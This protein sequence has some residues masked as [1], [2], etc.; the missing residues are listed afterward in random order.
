MIVPLLWLAAAISFVGEAPCQPV[1]GEHIL[2]RDL[3]LAEARFAGLGA[4]Q[5][6]G[7]APE[8]GAKRVFWPAELLRIAERNELSVDQPL[9]QV[10]FERRTR[11]LTEGEIVSAVR[12]WAPDGSQ[13][14]LLDQSEPAVPIG[15]LVLPKPG[16][17]HSAPDGSVLLRGY[18]LFGAERRFPMWARLRFNI[19]KNVVVASEEIAAGSEISDDQV[20]M[21][22]RS[23]GIEATEVATDPPQVVGR[24]ATKHL[25]AGE[26]IRLSFLLK[27]K[28]VNAGS[29]V[30]VEVRDGATRLILEGRAETSGRTGELVMVRNP[31]SGKAFQARVT[32]EDAVLVIP[33]GMRFEGKK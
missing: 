15:T 2:G 27:P 7:F 26:S 5:E 20:R 14:T 3:A 17:F 19:E 9:H 23:G 32:G 6:L 10:C 11:T 31:S 8:P 22:R 4:A 12:A 1:D 28:Q 13:V 21:E 30:R 33:P 16:V 25:A 24:V 18:V 29:V